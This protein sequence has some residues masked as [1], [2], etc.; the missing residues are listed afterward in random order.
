M[1]RI[2]FIIESQS[3]QESIQSLSERNSDIDKLATMDLNSS[4]AASIIMKLR[5][6]FWDYKDIETAVFKRKTELEQEKSDKGDSKKSITYDQAIAGYKQ[7]VKWNQ[8]SYKKVIKDFASGG[9]ARHAFDMAQ[10]V[11]LEPGIVDFVTK[12]IKGYGGD[13]TPM[14]RIQWDIESYA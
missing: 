10:N 1:N 12:M 5:K 3:I 6:S 14:E 11:A 9:G 7:K 4:K 13:E 8:A 2:Q